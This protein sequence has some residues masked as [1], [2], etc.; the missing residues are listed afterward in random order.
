MKTE[1]IGRSPWLKA[2]AIG[3]TV[4]C[5]L[6][7]WMPWLSFGVK[8]DRGMIDLDTICEQDLGLT[9]QEYAEEDWQ[10]W[11]DGFGYIEDS[12][13]RKQFRDIND[14]RLECFQIVSDSM[15]TQIETAR[16]FTKSAVILAQARSLA[17]K[18]RAGQ[19]TITY[20]D[21][22]DPAILLEYFGCYIFWAT[23]PGHSALVLAIASWLLLAA[24]VVV[25]IYSIC[26]VMADK[27]GLI[28]LEAVLYGVVLLAYGGFAL[29][30]N[31]AISERLTEYAA[32][33]GHS[34]RPFHVSL[35]PVIIFLCLIGSTVAEFKASKRVVPKRDWVCTCGVRNPE[36]AGFCASCGTPRGGS[37]VAK[38]WIC[39]CGCKNGEENRFCTKCGNP[40]FAVVEPRVSHCQKCGKEIPLGQEL[41]NACRAAKHGGGNTSSTGSLKF[42]FG[43]EKKK[44]T[45]IPDGFKPPEELG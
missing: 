16:F 29:V 22:D 5:I 4:L 38:T 41:C 33:V 23:L 45:E 25:G 44:K 8:T 14:G 12:T 35:L 19:E 32:L 20:E 2:F 26:M 37:V 9:F 39:A 21:M 28:W 15:M 1:K 42:N 27:R 6:S 34:I 31:Q 17:A 18:E 11:D 7:I 13:I 24:L 36:T 40:R 30:M 43:G 3:A 10:G